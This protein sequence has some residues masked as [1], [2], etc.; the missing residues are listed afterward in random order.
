MLPFKIIFA[1]APALVF[2]PGRACADACRAMGVRALSEGVAGSIA[3]A[4]VS[5]ALAANFFFFSGLVVRQKSAHIKK[6][7]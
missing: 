3:R 6:P 1:G 5:M 7:R 2:D 4:L